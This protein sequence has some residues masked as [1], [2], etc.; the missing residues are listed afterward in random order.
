MQCRIVLCASRYPQFASVTDRSSTGLNVLHKFFSDAG[1]AQA[2]VGLFV[3][4]FTGGTLLFTG[5]AV[6]LQRKERRERSEPAIEPSTSPVFGHPGWWRLSLVLRNFGVT[7][8]QLERLS[9]LRPSGAGLVDP[10]RVNIAGDT[11]TRRAN[12]PQFDYEPEMAERSVRLAVSLAPLGST[13]KTEFARRL[14]GYDP[15]TDQADISILLF[16]PSTSRRSIS[17]RLHAR[18]KGRVDKSM[19]IPIRVMTSPSG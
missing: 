2:G 6:H 16:A 8:V 13:N 15:P 12:A 19:S 3:A 14:V 4:L 7:T 18:R 11:S 5:I 1:W 9:V 10:D 17:M